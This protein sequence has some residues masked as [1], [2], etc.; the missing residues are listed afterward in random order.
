MTSGLGCSKSMQHW[1]PNNTLRL[2]FHP[3]EKMNSLIIEKHEHK[4]IVLHVRHCLSQNKTK[5]LILRWFVS[6]FRLCRSKIWQKVRCWSRRRP[7]LR[8]IHAAFVRSR[9]IARPASGSPPNGSD[10]QSIG[11]NLPWSKARM[12]QI[13]K[14]W[15][16]GTWRAPGMLIQEDGKSWCRLASTRDYNLHRYFSSKCP[17]HINVMITLKDST[18]ISPVRW[19]QTKWIKTTKWLTAID[20]WLVRLSDW[21]TIWRLPIVNV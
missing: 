2:P 14:R 11:T 4:K 21:F 13:M 5:R 9:V 18:R 7:P 19:L 10:R 12:Y 17:L 8:L 6:V 1:K 15:T 16:H 20:R 3:S